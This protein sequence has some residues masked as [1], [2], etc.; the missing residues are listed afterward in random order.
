VVKRIKKIADNL[1]TYYM[2]TGIM[3]NKV[4]FKS[5]PYADVYIEVEHGVLSIC[6]VKYT[7]VEKIHLSIEQAEKLLK[8]LPK[9]IKELHGNK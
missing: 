8:S 9:L 1:L 4:H 3:K 2:R 5:P 7:T 6:Q